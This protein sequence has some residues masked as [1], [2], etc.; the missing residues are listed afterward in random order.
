MGWTPRE[1][2]QCSLWEFDCAVAGWIRAQGGDDPIEPP[3]NEEHDEMVAKY[4][5]V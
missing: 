3:S 4:W 5:E 1:V 2:D